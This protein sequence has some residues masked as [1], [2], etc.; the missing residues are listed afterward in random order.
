MPIIN[1]WSFKDED[2]SQW[3]EAKDEQPHR[4]IQVDDRICLIW[5]E[6]VSTQLPPLFWPL[7]GRVSGYMLRRKMGVKS[8][9]SKTYT[10]KLKK[11]LLGNVCWN[12]N[13]QSDGGMLACLDMFTVTRLTTAQFALV[14]LSSHWV[15]YNETVGRVNAVKPSGCSRK[16]CEGT[17][18]L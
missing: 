1:E 10:V 8:P 7:G 16:V 3:M 4:S 12:R 17:F 13:V 14:R 15:S 5:P 11:C 6:T 2:V 9:T 18:T